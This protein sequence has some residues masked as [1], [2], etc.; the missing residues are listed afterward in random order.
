MPNISLAQRG[1]TSE[2]ASSTPQPNNAD[3]HY[4]L[5]FLEIFQKAASWIYSNTKAPDEDE[6]S[7]IDE[8]MRIYDRIEW[9]LFS[10]S[11]EI[12]TMQR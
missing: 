8:S 3:N 6:P 7:M 1:D 10:I 5:L 2:S 4:S 12:A 9:L 11:A